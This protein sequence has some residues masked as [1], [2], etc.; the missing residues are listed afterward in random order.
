MSTSTAVPANLQMF[1]ALEGLDMSNNVTG[2][3]TTLGDTR[4]IPRGTISA[5]VSL[6]ALQL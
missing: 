1:V 5:A 3:N 4:I 6:L 2:L